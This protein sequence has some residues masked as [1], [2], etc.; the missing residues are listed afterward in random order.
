MLFNSIRILVN[1]VLV[2]SFPMNVSPGIITNFK[3]L[4][5]A[6]KLE[7]NE[8]VQNP[9]QTF[10][11]LRK[12]KFKPEEVSRLDNMRYR[13]KSADCLSRPYI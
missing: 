9:N 8:A 12:Y 6:T 10:A 7:T 5:R 13:L 11:I 4:L 1:F 2:F 3:S